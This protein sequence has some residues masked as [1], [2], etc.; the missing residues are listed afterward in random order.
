MI[1]EEKLYIENLMNGVKTMIKVFK[2]NFEN[3]CDGKKVYLYTISNDVMSFSVT[4]YGGTIT[5][6]L[7]H[8]KM[9]KLKI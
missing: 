8:Q 7:F 6:I 4:N 2:E 5:K 9:V 1:L 3:S